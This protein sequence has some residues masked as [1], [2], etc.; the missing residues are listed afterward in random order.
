MFSDVDWEWIAAAHEGI[1]SSLFM[2][3]IYQDATV[4]LNAIRTGTEKEKGEYFPGFD[5]RAKICEHLKEAI[6]YY[7]K[8]KVLLFDSYHFTMFSCVLSHALS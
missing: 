6:F 1:S 3:L 7:K 8:E 2:I 5:L 4:A